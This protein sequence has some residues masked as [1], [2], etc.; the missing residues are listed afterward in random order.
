M[1]AQLNLEVSMLSDVRGETHHAARPA[2]LRRVDIPLVH[3]ALCAIMACLALVLSTTLAS[4]AGTP[5]DT[6][7]E[8][9]RRLVNETTGTLAG[10]T[11]ADPVLVRD[12]KDRSPA[13]FV[14]PVRIG[15]RIAGI[16]GVTADG[17][18]WQWYNESYGKPSFPLVGEAAAERALGG[19]VVLVTGPDSRL[20][21]T[22]A[23]GGGRLLSADTGGGG[24]VRASSQDAPASAV[25]DTRPGSFAGSE[26]RD[27]AR[28]DFRVAA[29]ESTLP[30]FRNLS[31]PHYYQLTSYYCGPASLQMLFDYYNPKIESQYDIANVMQAKVWD[32][33]SGAYADDLV[34]TARFS[35][36]SRAVMDSSLQGFKERTLGYSALSNFWSDGGSADPDYA[37][38]YTDLKALV[39][40]GHPVLLLTWYDGEHKAGHFRILKGYDDAAGTF[41]VHDPWYTAPFYGPDV[42]FR[43]GFLVDDLWTRYSRWGVTMAPWKVAVSA[44]AEVSAGKIFTVSASVRY[45]GLHPMEGRSAVADSRATLQLPPGFSVSSPT[46]GLPNVTSSGTAQTV[47]WTV[48]AP[49]TYDGDVDLRVVARGTY[50][51]QSTS[52]GTYTD[53][54]GGTGSRAISV[55]GATTTN[56]APT[57]GTLDSPSSSSRP[58][59]WRTVRAT[60]SDANGA[61]DLRTVS[62]LVNG[63]VAGEN[64]LYAA[65]SSYSNNLYLRKADNSAWLEP[66]QL[67]SAGILDN[68]YARLDASRTSVGRSGNDLTVSWVLG[69]GERM[70]GALHNVYLEAQDT[71]S[72]L[73]AWTKRGEW[74]V[75]RPATAGPV[76]EA[77]GVARTGMLTAINSSY[78]DPDGLGDVQTGQLMVNTQLAGAGSVWLRYDALDRKL[79]L[80]NADNTGWLGPITAGV[81]GKLDN[82]RAILDGA[83][84]K[85]SRTDSALNIRWGVVF[86]QSFSG[87]A[88]NL[89]SVASDRATSELALPWVGSGTYSVSA[90]PQPVSVS[91]TTGSSVPGARVT[92]TARY[93]DADGAGHIREALLLVNTRVAGASAV[94]AL[95]NPQTNKLYLRNDANTGWLGGVTPGGSG[96]VANAQA[97]LVAS[98]TAVSRSGTDL[99]VR[100][101]FVYKEAYSGKVYNA[102]LMAR[103]AAGVAAPWTRLGT[104]TV[105]RVPIAT[106]VTPRNSSSGAGA[107]TTHA[108]TYTD[109]D[110]VG[111]LLAVRY[112]VNSTATWKNGVSVSYDVRQNRIYMR[113]AQGAWIGGVAP[114]AS[115]KLSTVYGTLDAAKTTVT[116]NGDTITVRWSLTFASG[117]RNRTLYQYMYASDLAGGVQGYTRKGS[118]TVN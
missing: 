24:Q 54:I 89:Y 29:T 7:R 48:T 36:Q 52:Y 44:P 6:A 80:R 91:P 86:R 31:M 23:S 83:N 40:A 3:L 19:D 70:S 109:A 28:S 11:I 72:A 115:R 87:R 114:G 50:T 94:Y 12:G 111:T 46:L 22:A 55:V 85:V 26:A 118:W 104:W 34:R 33:W 100:W 90:V 93:R 15:D 103:D 107:T 57:L 64:A 21:W 77:G 42:R 61:S 41:I 37:T 78:S 67:G 110:G 92:H 8:T 82:G 35:N 76:Q 17:R 62:V 108:A 105:N 32:G 4:A 106:S 58:G 88:Y 10:G 101:S 71:K 1:A 116:R 68:G 47:S 5:A 45:L 112:L 63:R 16:V 25:R 9:A 95:Y 73:A 56:R 81:A 74:V 14:V 38:R 13:Y 113:D 117:M 51:G 2:I 39:N 66:V 84:T 75:N 49:S 18:S 60:Y 53:Y 99:V 96:T 43:Q 59:E 27:P 102:Y 98:G 30:S 97:T 69:P 65:Y 79:Y 20:Y